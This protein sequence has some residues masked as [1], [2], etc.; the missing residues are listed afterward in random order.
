MSKLTGPTNPIIVKLIEDLRARG[1]KDSMPF[2]LDVASRL[3]TSR[4][5]RPEVDLTKLQRVANDK[6]TIIVPGKV[7][8]TGVLNKKLNVAAANFS[9][10]AA[11][12]I[13]K[14]G[15]KTMTIEELV[16]QNPKGTDVKIV[17]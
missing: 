12:K 7:L 14:A 9:A 17:M 16:K 5:R 13:S 1:H 6:D 10:A 8:S 3:E 2:L 15:G 11:E 4:R